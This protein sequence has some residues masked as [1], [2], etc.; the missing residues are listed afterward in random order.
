MREMIISELTQAMHDLAR[1]FAHYLPRLIVMLVFAL[2]GWLIAYVVKVILRSILRLIQFDRISE[3]TGASQLL[4]SAALP[5]ATEMLSRFV[6]WLTWLGFILLGVSVLG[7][8]G[9]QEEIAKFFIF[10]P[11]LFA[12][13]LILFFGLLAAGF[14][15]RAALLAAVNA[16]M[17]SPRLLGL[18]IRSIM[19]VFVLSIVFEELGMA[20]QTMLVAFAIAFGA[21]MFG[22]AI[23]F[24]LG[25]KDLAQRFLE[26]KFVR[27]KKEQDEDELSPL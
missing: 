27:N 3:N 8:L 19:I 25:G 7:I 18:A 13:V 9:L 22:L 23:A 15:A 2:L 14:F 26:E 20:E 10:L 4:T 1:G 21:L 16:N 24:G 12:A 11:R 17:P 6:F 5:P